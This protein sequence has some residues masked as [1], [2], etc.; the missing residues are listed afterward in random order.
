MS[1]VSFQGPRG[2]V[3][4]D[5]ETNNIVQ[6]MYVYETVKV[7]GKLTQKVIAE[8]PSERDATGGCSL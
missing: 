5:P 8:L 7:Q 1:K 2:D 6:P 4:I 3:S